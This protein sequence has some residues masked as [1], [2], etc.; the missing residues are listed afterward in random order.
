[1]RGKLVTQR[2][3]LGVAGVALAAVAIVILVIFGRGVV[4]GP[5]AA[6]DSPRIPP[7]IN[8]ISC[9]PVD[10][11]DAR[12]TAHLAIVINGRPRDIMA[13]V[14]IA[15]ALVNFSADGQGAVSKA[16]CYYWLHT[17]RTDGVLNV[18]APVP[19]ARTFTL[20]DFFDIWYQPL[21][22]HAVGHDEGV[23][24]SYVNGRRYTGNPR[25]IPLTNHAV[26]QLDIGT[27]VGA[28]P[29]SP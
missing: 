13:N 21:G 6:A 23:V 22:T 11:L 12:L 14:G 2:R 4:S 29:Y 8:G 9:D 24:T 18:D 1:M 5:A 19:A 28:A 15:N 3:A 20:G 17:G 16:D 10:H 25:T 27:D 26:I 7:P